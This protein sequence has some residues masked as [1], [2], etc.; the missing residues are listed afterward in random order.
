MPRLRISAEYES[1]LEDPET[2]A[3]AKKYLA[4]KIRSGKFVMDSLHQ[5]RE[6]IRSIAEEIAAAQGEFFEHG[7]SRL[8]PMT[9][10]AVAEKLGVHE[11]TVG[12]AV[13]GK[14]ARTPQG[15]FELRFFFT[16]GLETA[17][18]GTI[19]TEAVKE[20]VAKVDRP[21]G[22]AQAA[23]RPGHRGEAE[24]AGLPGGAADRGEVP[25]AAGPCP[26][27]TSGSDLERKEATMKTD[28]GTKD[29]AEFCR[30]NRPAYH[31]NYYAMYSSWWDAITTEPNLMVVPVDDHMVHRGDGLF[32]TFKCVDG[33]IYNLDAHLARLEGGAKTIALKMPWSREDIRKIVGDVL[34]AGGHRDALVRIFVSRGPGG[35]SANPY[36]C[37]KPLL[38]GA[39]DP[40][41]GAVHGGASGGGEG[42]RERR[43]EQGRVLRAGEERELPPERADEEAGRGCRRGFHARVR[44]ERAHDRAA[45][46]E[47]RH[48]DGGP[49]AA[50][51]AAR[52]HPAG[53]HDVA[54]A[55]SWR[56]R[57]SCRRASSRAWRRRTCRAPNWRQAAEMLVFGTSPHVTAVT[58]FAGRPV[59]DGK[60]GPVWR[61]LSRVFEEDLKNPA[62]LT[63]MM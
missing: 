42:G 35:H 25:R 8:K 30:T 59:G 55:G 13:S 2:A 50:G 29:F 31:A 10:G 39:G 16:G 24:G 44:Q 37:P 60:P 23:L 17:D 56:A 20:A 27:R 28:F 62:M 46:G 45:D 36:E 49:R 22:R 21:R 48:R 40:A 5:R 12:R 6:T 9:M 43:A 4:E 41:G 18:G 1:M 53:H 32:E 19:S 14:Y 58:E 63:P 34:R 52:P 57:S 54:G 38:D 11:T 51:A 3:E 33:A 15:V 26:P 61:E 7:I 47:L